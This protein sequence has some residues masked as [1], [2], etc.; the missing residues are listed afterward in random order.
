MRLLVLGGSEFVGRAFVDE[1]LAA[2]WEVTTLSRGTSPAPVGVTALHGDRNEIDGLTALGDGEWDVV[3]DTWSW[4]PVAVRRSATLLRDR[5]ERYVYVSSRSVYAD[6][7]PAGADEGAAL[8]I[9]DPDDEHFDDYARAKAG[10]E[11][12]VVEEFGVRA[13]LARPG[14]IIGPRENIGRL[15]WWL[16]RIAA[17]GPVVAPGSPDAGIQYVDAR[18]LAAFSL[19]VAKSGHGG[20]FNVVSPV[21][22]ATVGD[23][24]RA[25]FEVTGSDA[26]L[27]WI[28]TEKI[29]AAGV[30]PWM[31][32]PV[33]L[34]PGED[35]EAM[36]QG[37]VSKAVAAGLR[38]RPLL[39][40]VADTWEW[41]QS[42][43]GEAPQRPDRPTL[44]L[45]PAIEAKLLG[46]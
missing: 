10:A 4:A 2:N 1:A 11:L 6:P 39:E 43:G 46:G 45:D 33:W 40:T 14:L 22:Q 35:H 23:L 7:V 31:D 20:P 28:D 12:A 15:P 8:V 37:D 5:T 30:K 36:H 19:L 24:L 32:L 38:I 34:P 41:L 16:N 17:G 21:G 27:R 42:I 44:G 26:E 3:V 29:L 13:I 18:D 9:A 25:C